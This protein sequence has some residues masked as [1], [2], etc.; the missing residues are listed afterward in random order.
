METLNCNYKSENTKLAEDISSR[1]T[2]QLTSKHQA[3][4]QKLSDKLIAQF[5]AET[6]HGKKSYIKNH[7]T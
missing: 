5:H 6:L 3:E 7:N 2:S 4:T 1:M